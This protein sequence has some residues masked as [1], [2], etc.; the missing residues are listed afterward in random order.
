MPSSTFEALRTR[1][2]ADRDA[3][4]PGYVS[5]LQWS[6]AQLRT[7]RERRMRILLATAKARSPWHRERLREVDAA[8][9]TEADLPSLPIMTKADLMA[10]FDRVLTGPR[11]TRGVVDAYVEQLPE[12]PYLFERYLVVASGGSSGR[13]GVF[14]YDWDG[15]VTFNC[16]IARWLS[17]IPDALPRANLYA[18]RGAHITWIAF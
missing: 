15:F 8:T 6:A 10:N 13:R 14:V 11:L 1:H 12:N 5:Q 4:L 17:A 7:E 16:Q 18:P 9:F 3:A 2:T